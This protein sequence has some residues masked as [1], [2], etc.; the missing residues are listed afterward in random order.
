[1]PKADERLT[2]VDIAKLL[3]VTP[4]AVTQWKSWGCPYEE[5]TSGPRYRLHKVIDWRLEQA[6][7]S[8]A[9]MDKDAE[10]LRKLT[11]EADLKEI[12]VAKARGVLV[13][14]AAFD[15]AIAAEHDL[16]RA[17]ILKTPSQFARVVV[18]RTGCTM[19]VA[20]TM[21]A[22]IADAQLTELSQGGGDD[23]SE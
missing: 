8:S 2:G 20:Q 21:L 10:T 5:A 15:E 23:D 7:K 6:K 17:I 22:D 14:M 16:T 13:P 4:A 19:A 9:P 3:H 18:D 12:E 1:M 11:A